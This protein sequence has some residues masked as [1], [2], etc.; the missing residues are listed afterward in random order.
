MESIGSCIYVRRR[1]RVFDDQFQKTFFLHNMGVNAPYQ[2][3]FKSGRSIS[4]SPKEWALEYL[5]Q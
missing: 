2:K 3:N 4:S 5:F 1:E